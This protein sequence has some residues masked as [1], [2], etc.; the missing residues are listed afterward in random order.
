MKTYQV[1]VMIVN[2]LTCITVSIILQISEIYNLLGKDVPC[3]DGEG[4]AEK[5]RI[6]LFK[7]LFKYT[8]KAI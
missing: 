8:F 3:I 7:R 6:L 1:I 2:I 4:D 5:K